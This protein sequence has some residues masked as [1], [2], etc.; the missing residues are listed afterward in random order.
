MNTGDTDLIVVGSGVAGLYAALSAATRGLRVSLVTKDALENSNSW[1]AQGGL[2]AVGPVGLAR[3]DSV[4][5]HIADTLIAGAQLNDVSA[6]ASMCESA[7]THVEALVAAGTE[8]DKNASGEFALGLEAAHAH[9]RI[10]HAGGDATGKVMAGALI[11]AC[12]KE[13]AAGRLTIREHV[14]VTDLLQDAQHDPE[15]VTGIRV[16]NQHGR[17][18]VLRSAAVLLATGG[19]GRLYAATTNPD[20]ATGDGAALA[21]RA[22]AVLADIEFVQFHPTLVTPGDFMISEAVR[23]EGAIL[24]DQHGERFMLSVHPDAELAPR[25]VVAR[26]IHAIDATGNQAFLDATAVETQ[27]GGGFLARRFPSITTSLAALG[28][29]LAVAPVPVSEA[30]H[31]WMGG[32]L[33]NEQGQSTLPGLYAAG[34]TACTGV[35]GAN[36]LAS[37]SL[38]EALTFAWN[39]VASLETSANVQTKDADISVIITHPSTSPHSN[40]P[41][42]EL[43][44]ETLQDVATTYLGVERTAAGLYAALETLSSYQVSG[45]D[46][47]AHELRN[48]LSLATVIGRAALNR[49]SSIG[50]HYRTDAPALPESERGKLTRYGFKCAPV[51]TESMEAGM[52]AQLDQQILRI[53]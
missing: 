2:T 39:T 30:A 42:R 4:A 24:I 18:E 32:V 33:T 25:D 52:T 14:F 6:V 11:T 17:V 38:L 7:W 27:H 1:Y 26:A 15:R 12:L 50:A 5:S 20:G 47:E 44:L 23:G 40:E 36:R 35:H 46:R 31:Y 22:G 16:L 29:D 48:L 10:L 53:G 34:E 43:N 21:Y 41:V 3:G 51:V 49:T 13:E 9:P 19:I 8:F 45:T 28:Y 37:N